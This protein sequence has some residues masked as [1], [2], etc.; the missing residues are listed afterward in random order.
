MA[1]FQRHTQRGDPLQLTGPIGPKNK[2]SRLDPRPRVIH[3]C[4]AC[5]IDHLLK[6]YPLQPD[7]QKEKIGLI[8]IDP[9]KKHLKENKYL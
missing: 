5:K 6:D 9:A 4:A 2:D 7:S 8:L 3:H 1:K